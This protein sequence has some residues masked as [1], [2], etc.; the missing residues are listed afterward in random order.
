VKRYG[1][2]DALLYIKD[3]NEADTIHSTMVRLVHVYRKGVNED[4]T[5]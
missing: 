4:D 1:R 5:I 3:V 2:K